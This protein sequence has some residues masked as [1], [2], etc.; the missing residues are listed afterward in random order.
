MDK[1]EKWLETGPKWSQQ[2][3]IVYAKKISSD[4]YEYL[5]LYL[6]STIVQ[7]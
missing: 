2:T 5:V 6:K 4:K 7:V 3:E 1:T